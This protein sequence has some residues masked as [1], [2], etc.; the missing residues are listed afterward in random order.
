MWHTRESCTVT[1]L[2]SLVGTLSFA[3]KVV[4]P[5]R[6]FLRRILDLLAATNV[7]DSR[8]I[9]LGRGF[10]ADLRWWRQHMRAWNGV[11]VLYELDWQS[12]KG[13]IIELNTDAC[14]VGAGAVCGTHWW[15]HKWTT[16]QL[17]AARQVARDGAD[18]PAS[19]PTSPMANRSEHTQHD[20]GKGV[21]PTDRR[22]MPYLELL[23]LT[24]AAATWGKQWRGKRIRFFNDC[25]PIVHA[26]TKGTSHSPLLMTLI[27]QLFFIAAEHEF[28]FRIEHI[29]GVT[30]EAA[31]ALSRLDQVRFRSISQEADH[32]PT[33][34]LLPP[35]LD[36]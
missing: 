7:I 10:R 5:G 30:N 8:R 28:E 13:S 16:D 24:M 33:I 35:I 6:I 18:Q 31:D 9:T 15:S 25:E 3:A 36:C 29:R 34:P 23:A 2:Q 4:R 32:S 1:E 22:S 14:E 17:R 20:E 21:M 11:S 19:P 27:R 26:V 12:A